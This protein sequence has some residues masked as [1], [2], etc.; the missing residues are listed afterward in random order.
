MSTLDE[1]IEVAATVGETD[2][3]WRAFMYEKLIGHSHESDLEIEWSPADDSEQSGQVRF[4]PI[5]DTHTRITISV[6]VLGSGSEA[7]VQRQ[8]TTDLREFKARIEED[9]RSRLRMAS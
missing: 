3:E 4:E 1:S 9:R 6:D 2:R 5:D 7:A 8:L